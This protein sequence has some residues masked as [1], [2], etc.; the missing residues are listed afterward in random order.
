MASGRGDRLGRVNLPLWLRI[1]IPAA[2]LVAVVSG[3]A[4][5]D[6]PVDRVF[7]IPESWLGIGVGA[8]FVLVSVGD[9]IAWWR[10]RG[11]RDAA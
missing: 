6:E 11:N 8:V 9:T 5:L 2:G 4:I 3:I 1:A 7:G 10:A